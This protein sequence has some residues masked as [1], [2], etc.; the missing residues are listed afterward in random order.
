MSE[1]P[2]KRVA[3]GKRPLY[4]ADPATDKLMAMLLTLVAELSVTRERLD[5]LERLLQKQGVINRE[6]IESF[7]P[8]PDTEQERATARAKYI[9]RVM[10][11]VSMELQRTDDSGATDSFS[12][13]LQNLLGPSHS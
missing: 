10:R 12:E 5:T 7:A 1:K 9:E 8:D 6:N 2:I 13:T 4:F 3:K 11:V